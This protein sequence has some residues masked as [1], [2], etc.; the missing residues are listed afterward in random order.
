M[1]ITGWKAEMY[2]GQDEVLVAAKHLV[3]GHSVTQVEGGMVD[4]IH[5]L[6]DTHQIVFGSGVPSESYFPG[7]AM[8]GQDADVMNEIL[9]LFPD[10]KVNAEAG[11]KLARPSIRR[12]EAQLLAA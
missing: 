1:L 9:M 5:L 10:F 6:F 11:W 7:H 4:Y 3:N 12:Y 2:F 8:F